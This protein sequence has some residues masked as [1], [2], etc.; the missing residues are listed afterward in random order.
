MDIVS[1]NLSPDQEYI[2]Q[3]LCQHNSN[4]VMATEKEILNGNTTLKDNTIAK[5]GEHTKNI[6]QPLFETM[7]L[8]V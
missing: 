7:E 8:N 4:F 6:L 5:I 1:V 3:N 2:I